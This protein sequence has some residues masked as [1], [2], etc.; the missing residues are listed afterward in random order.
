MYTGQVVFLVEEIGRQEERISY[1]FIV[2]DTGI[3]MNEE[4]KAQIFDAF[5]QAVP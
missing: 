2:K 1:R 4:E 3:G 5:S